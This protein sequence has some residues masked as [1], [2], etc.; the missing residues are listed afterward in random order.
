MPSRV[1]T[2]SDGSRSVWFVDRERRRAEVTT[3][4][5]VVSYPLNAIPDPLYEP[6]ASA[7]DGDLHPQIKI[8][9]LYESTLMKPAVCT[10]NAG[11][12][13]PINTATKIVRLTLTDDAIDDK[14]DDLEGQLLALQGRP[15]KETLQDRI[16]LYRDLYKDDRKIDRLRLG[17]VEMFQDATYSNIQRDPR[18]ALSFCWTKHNQQAA[19]GYQINCVTEISRP[20]ETFYRFMRC[21]R[22]LFSFKFLE[23]RGAEYACAYKFWVCEAKEKSLTPKPGFVPHEF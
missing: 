7:F 21:L 13:F 2:L 10:L 23:M 16:D 9:N 11:G 20:G 1:C 19:I 22:S 4:Q 14:L 17:A 6:M 5:V 15:F 12:P 3:D 8:Q 18:V